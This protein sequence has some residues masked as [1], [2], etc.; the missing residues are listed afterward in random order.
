M[1]GRNRKLCNRNELL[2]FLSDLHIYSFNFL[3]Y[4]NFHVMF[5]LVMFLF[6]LIIFVRYCLFITQLNHSIW[7]C[8]GSVYFSCK[9]LCVYN[10]FKA[11]YIVGFSCLH[12]TVDPS[13]IRIFLVF[14]YKFYVLLLS[15]LVPLVRLLTLI[16]L[17]FHDFLLT[18]NLF[19]SL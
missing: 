6:L 5:K 7:L 3:M 15:F 18:L 9:D 2:T 14:S 19:K 11:T 13:S 1:V 8:S 4:A 10:I 12:L 17:S 16:L